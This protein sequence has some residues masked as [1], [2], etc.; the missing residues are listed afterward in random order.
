LW[1]FSL[2]RQ[3]LANNYG[4]HHRKEMK[5]QDLFLPK[6]NIRKVMK[7][8]LPDYAKI[9]KE[10]VECIQECVTEF[11]SFTLG[12]YPLPFGIEFY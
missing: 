8:A 10:A 3:A 1:L 9:S 12:E 11:I 4:I 6:E 2:K 7:Q 5:E